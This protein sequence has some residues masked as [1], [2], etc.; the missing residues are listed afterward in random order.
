MYKSSGIKIYK[1]VK[2]LSSIVTLLHFLLL[3]ILYCEMYLL[4]KSNL[5]YYYY[6][7]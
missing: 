2:Y 3:T 1:Y 6:T 7:F 5:Y 4:Y